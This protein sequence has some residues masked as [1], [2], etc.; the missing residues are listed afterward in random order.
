MA[1]LPFIF[2]WL[3]LASSK[4]YSQQIPDPQGSTISELE[5]ILFDNVP[6]VGFFTGVTP[7]TTYIDSTTAQV[8]NS[9]GRQS[10]AQWIRAAFHDFVTADVASGAGGLDASIGFETHRPENVG[11][12]LNDSLFFF[13]FFFNERTSMADLVALG[14]VVA[15]GACGGQNIPFRGGRLDATSPSPLHVLPETAVSNNN[16]DGRLPFDKS[17]AAFDGDVVQEYLSGTGQRGG[18]LVT[19]TNETERSDLRLYASDDNRTM[20]NLGQSKDQFASTCTDL[21]ARMIDTV[22][23]EVSLTPQIKPS[24]IRLTK[25][26]LD[27]SSNGTMNL[28]AT[29]VYMDIA[30][31]KP[32]PE[33]LSVS[34]KDRNGRASGPAFKITTNLTADG[35]TGL[36]GPTHAYPLTTIFPASTGLSGLVI[37]GK[38]FQLQDSIFIVTSLSSVTPGVAAFSDQFKVQ[39]FAI[40][41]TVASSSRSS[42]AASFALAVPQPD[43]MNPRID[44][45]TTLQLTPIGH[46][47][48]YTIFSGLMKK[49]LNAFQF[50]GSTVDVGAEGLQSKATFFKLFNLMH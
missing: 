17:V 24:D 35:G 32:A 28:S 23:A 47:G 33:T 2:T 43:N 38:S 7:C 1:A 50:L 6:V 42:L 18:P 21:L 40:N 44:R 4:V 13:S 26:F 48:P 15:V 37:D 3:I 19:T 8:N 22:P 16:L 30:A 12:A 11:V 34:L 31:A 20:E 27:I 46:S 45:S 5:S 41:I 9:L 14:T 25:P 36:F 49:D 29:V 39:S 10:S